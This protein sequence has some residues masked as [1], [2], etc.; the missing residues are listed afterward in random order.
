MHFT[1]S[2][3]LFFTICCWASL[4]A[5]GPATTKWC[6]NSFKNKVNFIILITFV[7][8]V[9]CWFYKLLLRFCY[10]SLTWY[11]VFIHTFRTFIDIFNAQCG[12]SCGEECSVS[13]CFSS[14]VIFQRE[15]IFKKKLRVNEQIAICLWHFTIIIGLNAERLNHYKQLDEDIFKLYCQYK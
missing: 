3:S 1:I 7:F 14:T 5:L 13:I 15:N 10:E 9:L 6:K 11:S 2:S 4:Q 8:T 12:Q